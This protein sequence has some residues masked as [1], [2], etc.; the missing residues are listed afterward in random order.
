MSEALPGLVSGAL[1]PGA[2]VPRCLHE[3]AVRVFDYRCACGPHVAPYTELHEAS[4]ISF[5]R[6]GSFGYR[7][8]GRHHE[9]VP[10]AVLLG[11]AGET[12]E[13]THD[14]HAGGDECLSFALEPEL[15]ET[16]GVPERAWALGALPPLP[17]TG[18]LGALAQ[19]CADGASDVGL[20]EAGVAFAAS[21][22]HATW[23]DA[24]RAVRPTREQRRR[25]VDSALWIDVHSAE[26]LSLQ[27]MA[28]ECGLS[29]FHYLRV[30][31]VALG[32]TPH[33]YL[34]RARLR[35][36]ATLLADDAR[37]IT[38]VAYEVG[39][40]DLSNFVRSFG[41]AAGASLGAFRAAA[42][43][44]RKILQARLAGLADDGA[45]SGGPSSCSITSG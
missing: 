10:G 12:Y 9:L 3:G 27:A 42:R 14:H 16:I 25:A 24:R 28:A 43:G 17:Q 31:S 13:C 34:V 8:R 11:R 29:A 40:A 38:D 37:S 26:P 41:R 23:P 15:L 32:V 5:V 33:Q 39:F 4:S 20:D 45:S 6:R 22:A 7:Y 35:R 30:F 21:V 19:A 1:P 36:A 2:P 44:E 18:V